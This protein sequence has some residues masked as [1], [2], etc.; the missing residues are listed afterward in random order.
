MEDRQQL[1]SQFHRNSIELVKINLSEWKSQPYVDIRIWVLEDPAKPESAVPTKKGIRLSAD[2]LP[3]LIDA[4][5]EASRILKEKETGN[6]SPE[7]EE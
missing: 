3:K 1:I 7:K 5:N 6:K 4:L 2:L